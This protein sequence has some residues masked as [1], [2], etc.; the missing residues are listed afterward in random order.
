MKEL[1]NQRFID[2]VKII[3]SENKQVKKGDLAK[4]FNLKASTFSEI[5]NKRMN[6][7]IEAISILSS[8]FDFSLEWV[9]N[10][11]GKEKKTNYQEGKETNIFFIP[12]NRQAEY[13]KTI[14]D[15]HPL[16]NFD[17]FSIPGIKGDNFRMFQV[18]NDVKDVISEKNIVIAKQTEFSKINDSEYY[19]FVF[20]SSIKFD[21]GNNIIDS[22]VLE[23]WQIEKVIHEIDSNKSQKDHQTIQQ[24]NKT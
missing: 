20:K 21:K 16:S 6:A 5:L 9:I 8:K 10:G 23:A 15:K 7:P 4:I 3:I 19:A 11:T 24:F 17:T 13:I 14:T 18:S 12:L 1:V 22:N 2:C